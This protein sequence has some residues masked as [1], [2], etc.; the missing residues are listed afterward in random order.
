MGCQGN[1][2][3]FFFPV[4]RVVINLV[5]PQIQRPGQFVLDD[6][7]GLIHSA[8]KNDFHYTDIVNA[9]SIFSSVLPL[10]TNRWHPHQ[11]NVRAA[12]HNI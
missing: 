2:C 9:Q 6:K 3:K 10:I 5:L 1:L 11:F 4:F 8:V 12:F 7:V